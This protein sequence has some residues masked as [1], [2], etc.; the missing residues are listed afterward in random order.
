MLWFKFNKSKSMNT[1]HE[2]YFLSMTSVEMNE[3]E[4]IQA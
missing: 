1:N 4:I 3:L 2:N